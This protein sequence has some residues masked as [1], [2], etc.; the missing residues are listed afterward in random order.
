MMLLGSNGVI[1]CLHPRSFIPWLFRMFLVYWT[2]LNIIQHFSFSW[3]LITNSVTA[4]KELLLVLLSFLLDTYRSYSVFL[5]SS[6]FLVLFSPTFCWFLYQSS[7]FICKLFLL[8]QYFYTFSIKWIDHFSCVMF[9]FLKTFIEK[10]VLRIMKCGWYQIISPFH[11]PYLGECNAS[12]FCT[13]A[14]LSSNVN[15]FPSINQITCSAKVHR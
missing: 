8:T 7:L 6:S 11:D 13:T 12:A 15:L 14:W 4:F 10:H 5:S 3:F 9:I 2:I 1:H